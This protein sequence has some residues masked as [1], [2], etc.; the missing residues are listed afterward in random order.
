MTTSGSNTDCLL[1]TV[2]YSAFP[3]F[4]SEMNNTTIKTP[5]ACKLSLPQRPLGAPVF[6]FLTSSEK[7]RE[8]IR[9]ICNYNT[10][11]QLNAIL[12]V[13]SQVAQW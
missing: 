7:I 8:R 2:F 10:F 11:N 13:V 9:L 12:T 1:T 6:C 4:R 3:K 5:F